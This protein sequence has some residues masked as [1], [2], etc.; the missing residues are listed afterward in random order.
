MSLLDNM[1]HAVDIRRTTYDSDDLAGDYEKPTVAAYC[2]NE[3]AWVQSAGPTVVKDFK[4][5]DQNVTHVVFLDNNPGLRLSDKITVLSGPYID[6]V[7]I[8][9]GF[10][11]VTA[12]M[13]LAW[14]IY[15]ET[16]REA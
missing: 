6:E 2:A 11:E 14:A 8:V 7:L 1:P 3:P 13:D 4:N 9:R 10:R 5:R 16:D 15:A 12:G